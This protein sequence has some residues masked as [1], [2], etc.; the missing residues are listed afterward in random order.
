ML[1]CFHCSMMFA[2]WHAQY[3]IKQFSKWRSCSEMVLPMLMSVTG[4]VDVDV[5]VIGFDHSVV[6]VDP[7]VVS[8]E[9]GIVVVEHGVVCADYG[10]VGVNPVIFRR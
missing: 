3:N 5:V 6:S 7:G 10:V 1:N 8:V 2:S 4:I 9:S